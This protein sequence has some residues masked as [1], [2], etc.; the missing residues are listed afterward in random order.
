MRCRLLSTFFMNAG[1]V[2]RRIQAWA[3]VLPPY[4]RAT[5]FVIF[6]EEV[7]AFLQ[8]QLVQLKLRNDL[9]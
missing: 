7:E 3:I 9:L 4:N 2:T 8:D 6:R 5:K 1:G